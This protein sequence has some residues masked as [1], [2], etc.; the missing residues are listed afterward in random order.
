MALGTKRNRSDPDLRLLGE[1]LRQEEPADLERHSA[2]FAEADQSF[3]DL[4][5][6]VRSGE[7]P[8]SAARKRLDELPPERGYAGRLNDLGAA[9]SIL[10]CLKSG[11]CSPQQAR[12]ELLGLSRLTPEDRAHFE[13]LV[14]PDVQIVERATDPHLPTPVGA[15]RPANALRPWQSRLGRG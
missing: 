3:E 14:P 6:R 8:L 5:M 9:S 1:R 12:K 4:A 11:S 15:P 13:A 2:R 10:F 7:L